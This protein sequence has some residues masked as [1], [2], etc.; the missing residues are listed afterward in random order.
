MATRSEIKERIEKKIDALVKEG[1]LD[2]DSASE[3]K[4]ELKLLFEAF[5]RE[6]RYYTEDCH[7]SRGLDGH[8]DGYD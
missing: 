5:N 1:K 2:Q 7:L 3:L 4:A 6:L 8:G